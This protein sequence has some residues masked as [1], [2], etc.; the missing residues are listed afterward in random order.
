[1][2][3]VGVHGWLPCGD[4]SSMNPGIGRLLQTV[5]PFLFFLMSLPSYA[6][7]ARDRGRRLGSIELDV[8]TVAFCMRKYEVWSED[9]A[10]RYSQS[11]FMSL[12]KK[13]REDLFVLISRMPQSTHLG[14]IQAGV[15]KRLEAYGGCHNYLER[16]GKAEFLM[17]L[18]NE[19]KYSDKPF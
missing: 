3:G 18:N 6:E 10:Y 5:I 1:M 4:G 7:S 13:D 15:N 16:T 2:K 17:L 12:T 8:Y 14:M 19:E 11:V 9:D